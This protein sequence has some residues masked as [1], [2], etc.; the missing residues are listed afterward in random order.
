M[1]VILTETE[2]GNRLL[3]DIK[4]VDKNGREY[5]IKIVER[6]KGY[7]EIEVPDTLLNK[8][9]VCR[10]VTVE[11]LKLPKKITLKTIRLL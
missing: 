2:L 7:A 5:P 11:N 4:C 8:V 10:L 6:R 9:I 1:R 3:F